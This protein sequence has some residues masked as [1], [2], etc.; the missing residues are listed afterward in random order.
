MK[1]VPN[2]FT[3]LDTMRLEITSGI[4]V[5]T[6]RKLSPMTESGMVKVCPTTVII[7][8]TTYEMAPI[9]VMQQTN[10]SGKRTLATTPPHRTSGMVRKKDKLK[11]KKHN[12]QTWAKKVG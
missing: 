9:Q 11:G 4:L 2:Y 10:E 6:A 8:V 7:Q 12:H 3:Y 1:V 5:P